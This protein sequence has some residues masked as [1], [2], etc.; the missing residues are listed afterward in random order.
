MPEVGCQRSPVWRAWRSALMETG[1]SQPTYA[2][3][4]SPVVIPAPLVS[5]FSPLVTDW[6]RTALQVRPFLGTGRSVEWCLKFWERTNESQGRAGSR[7]RYALNTQADAPHDSDMTCLAYHPAKSVAVTGSA[8]GQ[9]KVLLPELIPVA[10]GGWISASAQCH[11][12]VAYTAHVC[13]PC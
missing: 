10:G 1:L 4:R 7:R 9:F 3:L 6:T 13:C 12:A 5:D 8:S 11:A 2:A